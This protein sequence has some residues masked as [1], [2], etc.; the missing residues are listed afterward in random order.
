[1]ARTAKASGKVKGK[2]KRVKY[3]PE[4]REA[5][6]K[7]RLEM[8]GDLLDQAADD[9]LRLVDE[10]CADE[11]LTKY[12]AFGKTLY[13]YSWNN[14]MLCWLQLRQRGMADPSILMGASAWRKKHKRFPMKG[15]KGLVILRPERRQRKAN[16][17]ERASG[18]AYWSEKR[19]EWMVG[20]TTF[21]PAFVFDV[22]QTDGDPLPEI[23]TEASG[24]DPNDLWGLIVDWCGSN[25][26][27]LGVDET[28]AGGSKRGYT[29]GKKVMVAPDLDAAGRAA[30]GA[31]EVGHVLLHFDHTGLRPEERDVRELEAEMVAY[32]LCRMHG[33]EHDGAAR[34]VACWARMDKGK[35]RRILTGS[36]GRITSA[37]AKVLGYAN[38]NGGDDD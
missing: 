14:L 24:D 2:R 30:V 28:L 5:L 18:Q 26:V 4:Q 13:R 17:G 9:F 1:M 34:Y 23:E 15:Q 12:L 27:T 19:G 20:W 22:Q 8:A 3:T 7:E 6:K 11:A 32:L 33:I 31:H 21:V 36:L 38:G 16:E 37:V 10:G 25:G 29:N 35:A